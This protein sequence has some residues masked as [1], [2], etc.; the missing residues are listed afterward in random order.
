MAEDDICVF[1][2]S[3]DCWGCAW[4]TGSICRGRR[5]EKDRCQAE[6]RHKKAQG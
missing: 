1:E 4:M 5:W 6:N 3:E 2:W